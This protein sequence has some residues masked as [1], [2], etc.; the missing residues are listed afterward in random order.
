MDLL[1]KL[2]A[3]EKRRAIFASG[4][5]PGATVIE[6][7]IG[8]CEVVIEGRPTLMFGSNNYL[9][10][11]NHPKLVEASVEAAKKY[12]AGSGAVRTISGTMSLHVELEQ[13][14]AAFKNV[15]YGTGK[16][17]EGTGRLVNAGVNSAD[18][19]WQTKD[20]QRRGEK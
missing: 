20:E 13:R 1:D 7:V 3:I 12:G 4:S 10:L 8:P 16:A 6:R 2:R 9:G 5:V 18:N 15:E 14:I 17:L 11:A 19:S